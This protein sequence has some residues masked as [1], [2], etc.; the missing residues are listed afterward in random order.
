MGDFLSDFASA[1]TKGL[2]DD[3]QIGLA[4]PLK[5]PLLDLARI[6]AHSTE[7]K[8]APLAAFIAGRYVEI[9][10]AQGADEASAIHEVVQVAEALLPQA[11]DK[12]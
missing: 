6:V 8:N 9:R 3:S 5:N 2:D 11:G 1:L 4:G 7:R 10:R 12:Q